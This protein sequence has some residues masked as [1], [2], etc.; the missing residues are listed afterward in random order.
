[1]VWEEQRKKK[2]FSSVHFRFV[3]FRRKVQQTKSPLRTL[4]KL[5]SL[6]YLPSYLPELRRK[7]NVLASN[8]DCYNMKNGR[9]TL[10][11]EEKRFCESL[12]KY[13]PSG[14]EKHN[15]K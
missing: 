8:S 4:A 13:T 3:S 12:T 7:K 6:G 15:Q 2:T 9:R 11:F 5:Y 10:N 14:I 1:M